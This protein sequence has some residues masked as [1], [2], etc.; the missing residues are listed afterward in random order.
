MRVSPPALSLRKDRLSAGSKTILELPTAIT[1]ARSQ[2]RGLEDALAVEEGAVA[3][4]GVP[5]E[6]LV[7]DLEDLGVVP[8]DHRL[9]YE[10]LAVG[11]PPDQQQGLLAR[12]DLL[13]AGA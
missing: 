3:A 5:D 13:L 12:E 7:A 1:L 10:D 6:V 9:V 2:F 11:K 8:R 4:A